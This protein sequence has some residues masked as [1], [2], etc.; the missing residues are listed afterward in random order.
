MWA[1]VNLVSLLD[2]HAVTQVRSKAEQLG[3][4]CMWLGFPAR[5]LNTAHALPALF[6]N[7]LSC[8]SFPAATASV[9]SFATRPQSSKQHLIA[10]FAALFYPIP[11]SI[12]PHILIGARITARSHRFSRRQLSRNPLNN[13]LRLRPCVSSKSDKRKM[14][15]CRTESSETA[16]PRLAD[17]HLAAS[18]APK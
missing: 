1:R 14:L 5:C 10:R 6:Y 9:A 17:A 15:W 18:P 12:E 11:Q 4:M 2:R 7:S 13:P 16:L 8:R 3:C